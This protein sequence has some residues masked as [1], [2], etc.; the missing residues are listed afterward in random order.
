MSYD[1]QRVR[2]SYP[3]LSDGW[4]Y[5]DGAAGTQVPQAVI[6]A[7][8]AAYAAG[9]GTTGVCLASERSATHTAAPCQD[10]RP[11]RSA[12][13]RRR[14]VGPSATAH[15]RIATA[16]AASG[17]GDEIVVTRP[18]MPI[19]GRGAG[20][21]P[22][23]IVR[24]ADQRCPNSSCWPRRSPISSPGMKLVAIWRPMCCAA[25]RPSGRGC[26]PCGRCPRL[27]RRR[28]RHPARAYRC[29]RAGRGPLCDQLLQVVGPA[30]GRHRG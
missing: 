16:C 20:R 29:D 10:R 27:R 7:E 17:G 8:A 6:E 2:A 25:R 3:A 24:W 15:H 28:A 21:G 1:V 12:F 22:G 4:A 30:P 11:G 23:M 9:I 19:S 18:S 26:R 14:R 13:A 5:L